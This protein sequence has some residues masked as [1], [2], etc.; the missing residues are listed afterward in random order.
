MVEIYGHIHLLLLFKNSRG[1]LSFTYSS[2]TQIIYK[3]L[4]GL[5]L[6][7]QSVIN[8]WRCVLGLSRM[9]G[10]SMTFFQPRDLKKETVTSIGK[11][12][13]IVLT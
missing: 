12:R 4:Q 1:S 3:H 5:P 2:Y 9:F 8:I 6:S 11:K 13:N 10:E 7:K